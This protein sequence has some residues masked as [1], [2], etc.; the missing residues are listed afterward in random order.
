MKKKQPY[1]KFSGVTTSTA[2]YY[3][4]VDKPDQSSRLLTNKEIHAQLLKSG[5][6]VDYFEKLLPEELQWWKDMCQA[7]LDKADVIEC[8]EL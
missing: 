4:G 3:H 6:L 2:I 5:F 7:Q 1:E 8:P